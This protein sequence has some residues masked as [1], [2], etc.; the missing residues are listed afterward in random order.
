[1]QDFSPD[2]ERLDD[3]FEIDTSVAHPAR[4]YN[5]WLGGSD[6]FA[7]D[8]ASGDAGEAAFPAVRIAAVENR[9][10]LH[11][12]VTF[13]VKD[14]GIRQFLDIGTGIPSAG[15][16]HEVA[17]AI[18]PETRVVYADNDPIVLAHARRLLTST[19]EGATA[20]IHADLRAP[21]QILEH[22]DL[23]NTLDLSRPVALMLIAVA[24]FLDDADDP[25]ARVRTLIGALAPGSCLA[26]SHG[27]HDFWP[28]D[29]RASMTAWIERERS[30]SRYPM[31]ARDKAEFTEFF[32]GLDPVPPGVVAASEW[33]NDDPPHGHASAA[34][35]ASY[36]AVARIVG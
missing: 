33:R 3:P 21:D 34:D 22:P 24:H 13:L 14:A 12:A 27:T 31:R 30:G 17:Q 4:R 36:A 8:R 20:Y 7:A 28:A 25:H 16:V 19:P 32:D 29:L 26:M 2:D 18:A 9:R 5:Y 23:L 11:R 6:N 10:F 15:N 35:V 1:M